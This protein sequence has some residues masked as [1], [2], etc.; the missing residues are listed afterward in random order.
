M[1]HSKTTNEV[2]MHWITADIQEF[3]Y[4]HH[5]L[6]VIITQEMSLNNYRS[7]ANSPTFNLSNA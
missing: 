7:Y 3:N 6:G 5:E 1:W 4:S 2:S